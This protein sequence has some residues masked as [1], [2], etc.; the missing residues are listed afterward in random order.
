MRIAKV[1]QAT[2]DITAMV[3]RICITENAHHANL[4]A[5]SKSS[6]LWSVEAYRKFTNNQLVILSTMFYEYI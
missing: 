1:G 6:T 4:A 2:C 5:N 3:P